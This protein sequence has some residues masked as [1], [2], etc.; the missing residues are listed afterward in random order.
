MKHL[1]LAVE[2]LNRALLE[3][4]HADVRVFRLQHAARNGLDLHDVA[5]HRVRLRLFE[6][7]APDLDGD[8]RALLA[9]HEL[10]RLEER[11]A[12]AGAAFLGPV[13]G[14]F[15]RTDRDDLVSGSDPGSIRR[16]PLDGGHNFDEA[17]LALGDLDSEAVELAAGIDLHFAVGLGA[18]ER[19]VGVEL[20]EHAPHSAADQHPFVDRLDIV[21]AH[22]CQNTREQAQI[23]VS[24][25]R[26]KAA[27][28]TGDRGCEDGRDHSGHEGEQKTDMLHEGRPSLIARS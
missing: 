9:A 23:L 4:A 7:L 20:T 3:G 26:G 5:D 28:A 24:R 18:H 6:A 15:G 8:L 16:G 14:H 22:E 25:R 21:L 13:L 12:L 19:R 1:D 10:D 17:V 11:H 27:E 2:I